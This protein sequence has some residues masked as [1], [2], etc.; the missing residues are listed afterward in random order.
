MSHLMLAVE[1]SDPCTKFPV[2][3]GGKQRNNLIAIFLQ[4]ALL[5]TVAYI[6]TSESNLS[7]LFSS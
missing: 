5:K 7:V 6:N 1:A 4:A 3:N 2:K